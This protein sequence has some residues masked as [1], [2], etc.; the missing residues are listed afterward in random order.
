LSYELSAVQQPL[1]SN[2][3][4]VQFS[5]FTQNRQGVYCFDGR[6]CSCEE[7]GVPQVPDLQR[8]IV[9]CA[10]N[11]FSFGCLLAELYLHRPLFCGHSLQAFVQQFHQHFSSH[12][13]GSDPQIIAPDSES[14]AIVPVLEAHPDTASASLEQHA[15]DLL[16]CT[17]SESAGREIIKQVFGPVQFDDINYKDFEICRPNETAASTRLS[18][19]DLT[20]PTIENHNPTFP[21]RINVDWVISALPCL[22][23]LPSAVRDIVARCVYPGLHLCLW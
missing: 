15:F 23:G 10:D 8:Q 19:Q 13:N 14:A 16:S 3:S 6:M 20:I 4:D 18:N 17:D 12:H 21:H 5:Q 9:D 7:C 1:H 22:S 11:V 2:A